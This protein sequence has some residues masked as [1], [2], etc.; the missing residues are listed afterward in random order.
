MRKVI[1]KARQG[2]DELVSYI[3]SAPETEGWRVINTYFHDAEDRIDDTTFVSF[4]IVNISK[5][6]AEGRLG[7][8]RSAADVEI[9]EDNDPM[10]SR[11]NCYGEGVTVEPKIP[12][13]KREW[14]AD[15]KPRKSTEQRRDDSDNITVEPPTN[16]MP[17]QRKI[18]FCGLQWYE[19]LPIPQVG[20]RIV[21]SN[22]LI[23][24]EVVVN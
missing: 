11:I 23:F 13:G 3:E 20:R 18:T 19:E 24:D 12:F 4:T 10:F 9:W 21:H 22:G 2:E 15:P 14:I 17:R 8:R 16:P 5:D 7:K 6:I 1:G